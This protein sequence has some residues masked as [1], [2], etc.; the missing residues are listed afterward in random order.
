M[1][2]S[3][4]FD[5]LRSIDEASYTDNSKQHGGCPSDILSSILM[6]TNKNFRKPGPPAQGLD[7][8][9]PIYKE[10]QD[11]RRYL[12]IVVAVAQVSAVV[13][14]F[15]WAKLPPLRKTLCL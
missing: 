2:K 3:L 10:V 13:H 9:R 15:G 11:A 12:M 8:A 14:T 7:Q 1:I 6:P 5:L 4:I